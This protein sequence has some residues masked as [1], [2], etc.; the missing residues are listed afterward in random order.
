MCCLERVVVLDVSI[1]GLFNVYERLNKK[2]L[3]S[4]LKVTKFDLQCLDLL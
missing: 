2:I 4:Y 1:I 3:K